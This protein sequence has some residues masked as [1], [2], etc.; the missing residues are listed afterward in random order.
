V[1]ERAGTSAAKNGKL[2]AGFIDGAVAVDSFGDGHRRASRTRR[3]DQ[4]W[5]WARAEAGE[6]RGIVPGEK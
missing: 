1:I 3:G 2:I 5:R 6:M 4:F